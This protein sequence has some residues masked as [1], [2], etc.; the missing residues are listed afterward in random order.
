MFGNIK[1]SLLSLAF[2]TFSLGMA[3]F[4]MMGILPD[5]AKSMKISIPTAGHF[6][7]AYALGVAFGAIILVFAARKKPLKNILLGLVSI[8]IIGILLTSISPN[9]L[10]MLISRF[11]SGL[12]HGGFFGIGSIVAS[13]LA[14]KAKDSQAVATMVAGMTVA[15]LIGI[16]LGTFVSHN[17]SWRVLFLL[18]G[19]FGIFVFAAICKWI[20]H[21]DA[22]PANGIL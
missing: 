6:I 16:P 18:I 9:Y 1:K 5:I 20:P 2:G 21:F 3:E 14:D 10:S 12:P 13:K 22:M 4:V 8:H 19:I 11:V 15:N 17:I 7:S